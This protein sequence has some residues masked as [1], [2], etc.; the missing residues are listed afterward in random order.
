MWSKYFPPSQWMK[1]YHLKDLRRDAFS[2][3]TLAAYAIP[4]S[5]AYASLA[6]LPVQYGIYGYLIGG[7][8]YAVFGTGLQLSVGPTS[9]IS[10][11]IGTT[12]ATLSGGDPMHLI[13]IASLTAFMVAIISLLAWLLRLKQFCQFYQ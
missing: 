2:G 4:V 10:L 5:M 9:A 8:F 12:L 1:C 11:L 3:I 6:G 13:G 7:L